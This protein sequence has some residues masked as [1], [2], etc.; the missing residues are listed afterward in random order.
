M[1]DPAELLELP[2]HELRKPCK[3]GAT[4]GAIRTSGMQDCVFCAAC[5]LFQYNAPRTETGKEKLTT[6]SAHNISPSQ[7]SRVLMR[8]HGMCEICG[9]R[10]ELHVG[11]ILSVAEALE[12]EL[13]PARFN[14]DDNLMA[15]C[16]ECN[17]G[18]G[19]NPV[20]VWLVV[21]LMVAR[22]KRGQ[23]KA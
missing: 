9:K 17:L 11:H 1:A 3:C 13:E 12:Q 5:G 14:S 16:P 10:G 6:R 21:G 2:R 18:L 23:E 22:G 4:E 19:K 20:P 8:A 15:Q 7:R